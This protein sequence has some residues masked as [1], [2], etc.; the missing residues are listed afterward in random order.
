[1]CKGIV[2]ENYFVD[3]WSWVVVW[4]D[5]RLSIV[6]GVRPRKIDKICGE[7]R[8]EFPNYLAVKFTY[9]YKSKYL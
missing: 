7:N 3:C 4:K 9:S 1:M 8:S 2:K 6:F 5:K